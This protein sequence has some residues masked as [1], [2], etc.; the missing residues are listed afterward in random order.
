MTQ[1]KNAQKCK[2]NLYLEPL[3]STN[4]IT[5]CGSTLVADNTTM[6]CVNCKLSFS[7]PKFK[8]KED[9]SQCYDAQPMNSLI[10]EIPTNTFEFCYEN[11][12]TCYALSSNPEDQKCLSCSSNTIRIHNTDNC[13]EQCGNFLAY[14][15]TMNECLYC[16]TYNNL[17]I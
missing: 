11:C 17:N 14:D 10:T 8:S 12:G 6:K 1:I 7:P 3:P 16:R 13:I 15:S 4:C 9:N 2:N 5:S